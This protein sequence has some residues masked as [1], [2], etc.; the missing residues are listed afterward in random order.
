MVF[1]IFSCASFC[2]LAQTQVSI[3]SWNLKDLG[4]SKTQ[5][6][7]AF[8][9]NLMKGYD[10]VA[11]QEVV[12]GPNGPKAVAELALELNRTG[13][14]W[15]YTISAVTSGG[16]VHKSERYAVLWKTARLKK[17]GQGWLEKT[18]GKLIEREPFYVRFR[19]GN[20]EFQLAN[21]HAITKSK[22]PETEIKYFKFLP[23]LYPERSII[24]CGDYNLPQSHSVFEPLKKTGFRPALTKQKTSL[25]QRCINGDCLASEFDNFFFDA[26]AMKLKS[27]GVIHFYR[28]FSTLKAARKL[29]DHIPIFMTIEL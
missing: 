12:A 5:T 19:M 27:A 28:K 8:M 9:A 23:A 7:F 16:S 3:L 18:Y 17:L 24:F 4:I 15:D 2:G 25:R 1:L 10:L 29:S 13:F 22:Q 21:Y 11:I 26:S 14:S 6:E 20:K